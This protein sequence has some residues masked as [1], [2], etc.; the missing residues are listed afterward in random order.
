[1]TTQTTR[2]ERAVY[3][4][5]RDFQQTADWPQLRLAQMRQHLAEHIARDLTLTPGVLPADPD[6]ISVHDLAHALD[7]ST[8]Y[9]V[10]LTPTVTGFMAERLL[11]MLVIGKRDEH[12]VWQPEKQPELGTQPQ[13]EEPA[14][15]SAVVAPPT[16]QA[17]LRDRIA[18]ALMRWTERGNSP[19]YAAMRRPETVRANAYSRADAALAVL[20]TPDRAAVLGEAAALLHQRARSIDAL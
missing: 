11:E 1:M 3:D 14:V 4:A 9:P 7:N 16:D 20:P 6:G 12:L 17:A 8:P 5:L 10:E 18:E 2:I 19:Q 13:P 15:S